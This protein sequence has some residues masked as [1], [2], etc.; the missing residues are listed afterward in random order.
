[1]L[2][3]L[4]AELV[5]G[6][7]GFVTGRFDLDRTD[8][9][10]AGEQE[11]YLIV[12]LAAGGGPGVIEKLFST[13][14]QHLGHD[15]FIDIAKIGDQLVAEKLLVYD[16]LRDG[17]VPEGHGDEEASVSDVHLVLLDILVL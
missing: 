9:K 8:L 14:T 17:V 13:G 16:V 4:L 2:R 15:V 6:F 1:M 12:V 10:S 5:H 11:V 7:M 3:E